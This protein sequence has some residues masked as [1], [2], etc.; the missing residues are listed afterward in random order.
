MQYMQEEDPEGDAS[1][2]EKGCPASK[3][4]ARAWVSSDG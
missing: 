2:A 4:Q 3:T 1:F